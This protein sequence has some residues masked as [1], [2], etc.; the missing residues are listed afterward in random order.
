MMHLTL[1]GVHIEWETHIFLSDYATN[2]VVEVISPIRNKIM[3]PLRRI[4]TP[5]TNLE[6]SLLENSYVK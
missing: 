5:K 3:D 2:E 1:S 6:I 4:H